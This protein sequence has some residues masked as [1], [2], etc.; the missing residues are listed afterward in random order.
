MSFAFAQVENYITNKGIN[1]TDISALI[2]VLEIAF[3]DRDCVAMTE[4]RL[5]ALKQT[6]CNFSTCYVEFQCYA[7][8]VQ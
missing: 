6:N 1:L 4:R 8:N 3:R 7:T 2:K 5:E